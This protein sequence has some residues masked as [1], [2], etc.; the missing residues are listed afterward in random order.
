MKRYTWFYASLAYL[1]AAALAVTYLPGVLDDARPVIH[2]SQ[3]LAI[4]VAA[5]LTA[6]GVE[7]L[8]QRSRN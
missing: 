4:T 8:R 3:H 2:F 7:R 1:G 6:Y 5:F